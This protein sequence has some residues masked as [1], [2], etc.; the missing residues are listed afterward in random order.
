MGFAER[1]LGFGVVN[2][3]CFGGGRM[4]M[5]FASTIESAGASYPPYDVAG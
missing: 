3:V 4:R 5:V 2:W 1:K